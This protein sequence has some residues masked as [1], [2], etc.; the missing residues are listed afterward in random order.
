MAHL[1]PAAAC[2]LAVNCSEQGHESS[3]VAVGQRTEYV[4]GESGESL[5]LPLELQW[6]GLQR[7]CEVNT[8]QIGLL[9]PK[10]LK[11]EYQRTLKRFHRNNGNE[12]YQMYETDVFIFIFYS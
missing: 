8:S 10:I 11:P 4:S 6:R 1:I 5:Y 9:K 2:W 12:D 3:T 7:V